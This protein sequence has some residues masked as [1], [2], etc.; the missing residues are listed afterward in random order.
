MEHKEIV[1]RT[2]NGKAGPDVDWPGFLQLL[3]WF[4]DDCPVQPHPFRCRALGKF[5]RDHDDIVACHAANHRAS[6]IRPDP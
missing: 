2:W 4:D 5:G 6:A 3:E 1:E